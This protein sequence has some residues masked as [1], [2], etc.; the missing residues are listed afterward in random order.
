MENKKKLYEKIWI[1]Q[2]TMAEYSWEKDGINRHQSYKYITEQQYKHNFKNAL[3]KAELLWKME[4]LDVNY[5]GA[6]SEKMHLILANFEGR[7]ID[8][9]TG[10]YESFYF[11]GSGADNGDKAL[12]KAV[13]GGH[14]FFLA[15]NFNISE[16]LDPEND[17]PQASK[18]PV[19]PVKREEIKQEVVG[20]KKQANEMMITTLKKALQELGEVDETEMAFI[21]KVVKLTDNF[22]NVE[23]T[24]CEQLI[25]K[26]NKKIKEAK[27]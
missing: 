23:K 1:L 26:V 15:A 10:E 27:K 3:L 20:K 2:K 22:K 12:Y 7:L 14:K 16:E 8:P 21:E 9:E 4:T 25:L 6:I 19:D 11:S 5:V 18:R 17:K 24:A 13:T